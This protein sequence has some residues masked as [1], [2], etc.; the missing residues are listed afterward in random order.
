MLRETARGKA[1]T[2][3]GANWLSLAAAPTFTTMA[4]LRAVVGSGPTDTGMVTMYL[5]MS[6]L[7]EAVL[8]PTKSFPPALIPRSPDPAAVLSFVLGA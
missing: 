2:L 3:D 7:A 4:V 6:A 5:L 8:Q 1:A